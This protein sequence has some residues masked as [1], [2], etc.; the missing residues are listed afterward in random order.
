MMQWM[1]ERLLSYEIKELSC[2]DNLD[3][4]EKF[5]L[6]QCQK[7]LEILNVL[8]IEDIDLRGNIETVRQRLKGNSIYFINKS[9]FEL[10]KQ[11]ASLFDAIKKLT[12]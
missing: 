12:N 9:E 2:K 10:M 3:E 11:K 5:L 8:K 6:L 7:E 1:S 4:N